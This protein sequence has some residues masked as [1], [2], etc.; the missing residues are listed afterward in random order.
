MERVQ[1][2]ITTVTLNVA[3]DKAYVVDAV[4][5]GTVMRVL[6]RRAAKG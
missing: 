5:K 3:I 1:Q 4:E 6:I 2:M